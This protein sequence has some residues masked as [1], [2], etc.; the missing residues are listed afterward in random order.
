MSATPERYGDS[1]GTA[2]LFEY[3]GPVIPP[4]YTLADAINDH[5]LVPYE[6]HPK[7]VTLTGDECGE[8]AKLTKEISVAA[9]RLKAAAAPSESLKGRLD[10]LLIQRARIAKKAER[11]LTVAQ[12]VLHAY[13]PGQRWLVYCEDQEQLGRVVSMTRAWCQDVMEYHSSMTGDPGATLQWFQQYGGILVAIACLDEGVNIPSIS[14]ALILASSQNPRQFIQR[15]GRILRTHHTKRFAV[16]F[17]ALVSPEHVD[18][19][20]T[21]ASLLKSELRRSLEFA[22]T[23]MNPS[24]RAALRQIAITA[25]IDPESVEDAGTELPIDD[26]GLSNV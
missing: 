4:E 25:G 24:A 5:H 11:K 17:D 16:V 8:W 3:F 19:E 23:A 1:A 2:A 18:D 20:P 14:H 22:E 9:A 13:K 15:R 21:Q 12:D 6:Y 7:M 10:L 26:E